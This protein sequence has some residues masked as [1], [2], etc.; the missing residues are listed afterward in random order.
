MSCMKIIALSKG[1]VTKV[2]DEDFARLSELKWHVLEI[3]KA[4]LNYAVRSV[5]YKGKS[6]KRY[7]H[8]ELVPCPKGFVIDHIDGDG[9]NNTRENLRVC[10]H[11][12]NMRNRKPQKGMKHAG[13][14]EVKKGFS[15]RIWHEG[16]TIDLGIFKTEEEAIEVRNNKAKELRGEF[17]KLNIHTDFK[18]E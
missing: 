4:K 13:I 8:K 10:S 5:A 14:F 17:A 16:R 12:E 15:A 9:L 7:M 6:T 1:M 18:P 11:L 3:K 2:S